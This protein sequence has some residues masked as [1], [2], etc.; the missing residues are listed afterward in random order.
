[1]ARG[2]RVVA[3]VAC[4]LVAPSVAYAQGGAIRG[5]V[6]DGDTGTS[7][8]DVSVVALGT[9]LRG[10][11]DE[12]GRFELGPLSPGTYTLLLAHASFTEAT[13]E[14]EVAAGQAISVEVRLDR[15]VFNLPGL[16]VTA[17]RN[18]ARPGDAPVSVAVMSGEEIAR[19]D[20]ISLSEALPYA[21]GVLFNAGQMDIRGATGLA[22]GV[23][24]RVLMLQDGHRVLSGVGSSIEFDAL[25]VLDVDR[26]E[27][28]KG[29]HS[30]LFGSNALGGVVNVITRRPSETPETIVQLYYGLF[31]QPSEYEFTDE[32]LAMSGLKV[33]HTNR[34]GDVG[35]TLFFGRE[36]T[37]GFR[38]NGREERWSGRVKTV[39][40]AA[41]ANP[42]ELFAS[43]TRED[44]EEFFTWLSE[45]RPLEVDPI[46][47]GDWTR[48]DDF[49]LGLTANPVVTE[50]LRLQI[51]PSLYHAAVTNH[52]H[53]NDGFHR[54]TRY[55][56]DVQASLYPFRDH[57][58]TVGGEIAYTPVTSNFLAGDPTVVDF[59]LFAQDEVVLSDTWRGSIGA[60]LDYHQAT[61]AMTDV[62]VSPKVGVVFEPTERVSLRSSISRGYRAPS[63]SEQYTATTVFGFSVVP[64]YDLRGETA[65][66]AEI[67][68]TAQVTDR[69]WVDAALFWSEYTNLIEPGGAPGQ[70]FVFQFQN[71]TDA[72]VRGLD[73]GVRVGLVPEQLMVSSN[74][75]L[76][77][78]EDESTGRSLPYRSTHNLTTTLSALGDRIAVDFRYR[79]RVDEVLAFPL[80][81]RTAITVFDLRGGYRIGKFDLQAKVENLFQNSYVDVQERSP[82]RTRSFRLTVTPRF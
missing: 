59:A 20:V 76:L 75:V 77:D 74:Y 54:S 37:D 7:V 39:F 68:G 35:A 30:T 44:E 51:R 43:F 5:V 71:I 14:V 81:P 62:A 67:G 42:W 17:S 18:D 66:A 45:D 63:I 27:I 79:S 64:N 57:A 49:V 12:G 28:V 60:R 53:D 70:P 16:V 26:V 2:G 55:G 24:S 29:P 80:D 4:L 34:F 33:Q 36:G 11:S 38:Q 23:G 50:D 46:E 19:R 1:M 40:P 32:S 3:V 47:L 31:D 78:T 69:V 8:A 56:A 15:V 65:W 52:F 9:G 82:G 22:R 61:D 10:L 13:R 21:Q 73:A 41:S 25:P 58:L 72:R 6:L 48:E